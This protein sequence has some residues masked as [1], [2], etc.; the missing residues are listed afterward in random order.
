MRVSRSLEIKTKASQLEVGDIISFKL[1]DGEK[2]RARAVK[3]YPETMLMVFEDCLE[4]EYPMNSSNTNEGGYLKSDIR[5]ILNTEIFNRF[6]NKI[7][8]HMVA[9]YNGD[10]LHLLS[11]EEVFGKTWDDKDASE[12]Q[13]P[14]MKSRKNRI[15]F[16]GIDGDSAWWWLSTPYGSSA[17]IFCF[18]HINGTAGLNNASIALGLAPAFY[19]KIS[20]PSACPTSTEDTL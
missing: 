13:I 2:V 9:D 4:K 3:R 8:K 7:R 18:V 14:A 20:N 6:P 12:L 5:R 17:T 15:K 10:F 11:V 16:L 1:V 19:L